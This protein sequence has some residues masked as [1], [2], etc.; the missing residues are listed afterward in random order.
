MFTGENARVGD[1]KILPKCKRFQATLPRVRLNPDL[2]ARTISIYRLNFSH[3]P[4]TR[5]EILD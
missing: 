4:R 2:M 5:S 3:F 1:F